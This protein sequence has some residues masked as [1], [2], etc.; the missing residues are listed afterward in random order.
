[1]LGDGDAGVVDGRAAT[2]CGARGLG[3]ASGDGATVDDE[4]ARAGLDAGGAC[5]DGGAVFDGDFGVAGLVDT[6][7][8]NLDAAAGNSEL[9]LGLGACDHA[10]DGNAVCAAQLAVDGDVGS[11]AVFPVGNAE[12]VLGCLD[13]CVGGNG[14]GCA[15]V[16][17]DNGGVGDVGALD[18][19]V[20]DDQIAVDVKCR[21]TIDSQGVA[22]EVELGV[23]RDGEALF[24]V[25]VSCQE[26]AVACCKCSRKLVSIGDLGHRGFLCC[27]FVGAVL[28][29]FPGTGLGFV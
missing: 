12:A 24:E 29:L 20:V 13:G 27:V 19:A 2:V 17:P 1:M 5:V 15:L 6:V 26:D 23:L 25:E 11:I 4:L 22:A 14:E 16:D 10:I 3:V 7:A 8:A 9:V 21:S 28:G 18:G